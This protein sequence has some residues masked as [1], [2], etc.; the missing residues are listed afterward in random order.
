MAQTNKRRE[1]LINQGYPEKLINFLESSGVRKH[2]LWFLNQLKHKSDSPENTYNFKD[3]IKFINAHIESNGKN[4]FKNIDEAY[5]S[6]YVEDYK[7]K[8]VLKKALYTFKDGHSI[9]LLK[10]SD[11]QAEGMWMSNCIGGYSE[12]VSSKNTALLA[13]KNPDGDTLVHFEILKNGSLAQNFE[14]AN[15]PVR[16]KY[17]KYVYEFFKNNSKNIPADKHFGF[18]WRAAMDFSNKGGINMTAQCVVPKRISKHIDNRGQMVTSLESSETLKEFKTHL[19][20]IDFCEF[21]KDNF[22]KKLKEAKANIIK[23]LDDI[24]NN[25]EI[26]DG[27]NLFVSDKIKEALFGEG[28]YLMKGDDYNILDLTML[29]KQPVMEAMEEVRGYEAPN[30][31]R[32]HF[33]PAVDGG[34]LVEQF[35]D[36][37][38]DHVNPQPIVR[39][40]A[41]NYA[42]DAEY[43][44]EDNYG[45]RHLNQG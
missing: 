27:E 17:W 29:T 9:V 28:S 22:V 35:E 34:F 44:I 16:N 37:V 20:M 30:A 41:D 19:P 7:K 6:A 39:E 4:T 1:F 12:N 36:V 43:I 5:K 13:L 3:T 26:T 11:L 38:M 42:V 21:D 40:R 10:P 14:K 31:H 8:T 15:M 25:A 33:E 24:I 2:M 45:G 23:S 32:N 18:A